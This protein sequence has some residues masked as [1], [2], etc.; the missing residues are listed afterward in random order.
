MLVLAPQQMLVLLAQ[1]AW[2][3]TMQRLYMD[4]LRAIKLIP[5]GSS[6]ISLT[7][8]H[9]L[10]P[11]TFEHAILGK[12]LGKRLTCMVKIYLALDSG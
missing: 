11:H 4:H 5:V 12:S 1:I 9:V 2:A 6:K 3:N 10:G 7:C 8:P